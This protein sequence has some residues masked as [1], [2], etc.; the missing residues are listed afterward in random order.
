MNSTRLHRRKI[1][2]TTLSGLLLSFA[3]AAYSQAGRPRPT[4]MPVLSLLD[5]QG[6]SH[7]LNALQGKVV[8]VNFWATWCPPC[9]AEMPSI[10][11]LHQ[12]MLGR[13]F[14]VLAINQGESLEKIKSHL[15]AFDP[16]PTFPLLVDEHNEAGRYFGISDLPMTLIFNK[17]GVLVGV[18]DGARDFT[19]AT[20]RQNIE[21]LLH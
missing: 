1:V 2:A 7:P 16:Q 21:A 12:A 19:N 14:V 9:R 15:G 11:K 17:T 18:A 8:M 6:R 4:H 3:G 13:D 10:E 5:L 20:I